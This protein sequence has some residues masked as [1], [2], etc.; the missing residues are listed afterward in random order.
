MQHFKYNSN[1]I[2]FVVILSSF[3]KHFGF[4]ICFFF[5]EPSERQNFNGQVFEDY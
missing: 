2:R 1:D 5:C 4:T 3:S